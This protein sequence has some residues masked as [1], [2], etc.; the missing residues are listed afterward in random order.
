MSDAARLERVLQ[1]FRQQKTNFETVRDEL[2][3]ELGTAAGAL[4]AEVVKCEQERTLRTASELELAETKTELKKTAAGQQTA[5]ALAEERGQV[6][7]EQTAQLLT[8]SESERALQEALEAANAELTKLASLA[9][10]TFAILPSLE[11][12]NF[13]LQTELGGVEA[14]LDVASSQIANLCH[15]LEAVSTESQHRLNDLRGALAQNCML[16]LCNVCAAHETQDDEERKELCAQI[17]VSERLRSANTSLEL[18]GRQVE[19]PAAELQQS[20]NDPADFS[21]TPPPSSVT[22]A[23]QVDFHEYSTVMEPHSDVSLTIS[24]AAA[25]I[26]ST[27]LGDDTCSVLFTTGTNSGRSELTVDRHARFIKNQESRRLI[28]PVATH[29]SDS[30]VDGNVDELK[31]WWRQ[32]A[33]N[34]GMM[35]SSAVVATVA[36]MI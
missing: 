12:A 3:T 25:T 33:L 16:D 22:N 24:D 26:G 28:L 27:S 35:G 21:A 18:E 8:A 31:E 10:T 11:Q 20:S 9:E 36:S 29:Q 6:V 30:A 13:E 23:S 15:D 5:E 32:M 14:E 17:S 2:A 19:R 1:E 7:Q 34:I 4:T